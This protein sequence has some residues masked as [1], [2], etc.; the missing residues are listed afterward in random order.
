[1]CRRA[2]RLG[3]GLDQAPRRLVR[4]E[5]EV[6]YWGWAFVVR[7]ELCALLWVDRGQADTDRLVTNAEARA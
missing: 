3:V 5:D 2:A 6:S 1:M 4:L 7:S